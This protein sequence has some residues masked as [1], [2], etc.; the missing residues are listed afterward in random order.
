MKGLHLFE[1]L[2]ACDRIYPTSAYLYKDTVSLMDKYLPFITCERTTNDP[3]LLITHLFSKKNIVITDKNI[4]TFG[5]CKILKMLGI[6]DHMFDKIDQ[7]WRGNI[8]VANDS[9]KVRSQA[10]I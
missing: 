8:T 4:K 5:R 9:I 3:E 6:K 7:I 1:W 2:N 10:R